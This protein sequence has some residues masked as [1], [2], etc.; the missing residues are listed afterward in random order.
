MRFF[1]ETITIIF[2]VIF[3]FGID[4]ITN[5]ITQNSIEDVKN[6]VMKVEEN[7]SNRDNYN[8]DDTLK[9]VNQLENEWKEREEKLSFFTEHDELEK[10]SDA[11]VILKSNV[12]NNE[13][14]D[15]SAKIAELNFEI[16]H[17]KNKQKLMWNNIF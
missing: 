13:L 3:I 1:K 17:I 9:N 16:E 14:S 5:R 4:F 6:N 10:V 12:E 7:L 2:I 15:A 11:I 8:K